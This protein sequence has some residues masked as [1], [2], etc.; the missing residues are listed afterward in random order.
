MPHCVTFCEVFIRNMKCQ[1][2][3]TIVPGAHKA[4]SWA[5]IWLCW[6]AL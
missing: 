2:M 3:S 4:N 5:G 6:Q 1:D